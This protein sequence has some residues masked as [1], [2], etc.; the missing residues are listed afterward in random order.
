MAQ[1]TRVTSKSIGMIDPKAFGTTRKIEMNYNELKSFIDDQKNNTR[2]PPREV[3]SSGTSVGHDEKVDLTKPYI[4]ETG[5]FV[6]CPNA[7]LPTFLTDMTDQIRAMF[8]LKKEITNF[9]IRIWEPATKV[10]NKKE[11]KVDR[12]PMQAALSVGARIFLSFGSRENL[13]LHASAGGKSGDCTVQ[14]FTDNGF[15]APIGYAAGLDA[16]INNGNFATEPPRKGFRSSGFK[17]DPCRRFFVVVD[18]ITN[19]QV[20]SEAV[21]NEAK[22]LAGGDTAK[23]NILQSQIKEAL[24][25]NDIDTVVNAAQSMSVH[26]DSDVLS[27]SVTK[28]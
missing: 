7:K 27:T 10:D 20:L 23:E 25:L 26:S 19:S 14:L 3:L 16:T 22:K 5:E 21:N 13:I 17:K 28:E 15:M 6:W 2:T 18:C 4:G 11:I 24:N 8:Q 1:R 12:V 9:G